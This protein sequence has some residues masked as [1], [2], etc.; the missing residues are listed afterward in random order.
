[1]FKKP[2]IDVT[3]KDINELLYIECRREDLNLDYK[4]DFYKD[5]KEFSKDLT[6]FANSN[7]GFIILGIDEKENEVIG[8]KDNVGRGKIEDWISNV[9]VNNIDKTVD[10]NLHFIIVDETN[11]L[12]IV[13]IEIKEHTDKPVYVISDSKTVCYLRKGTSIFSANPN[14]IKEMYQKSLYKKTN[15]INKISQK[16]KGNNNLQVVNNQGTI[17]KT[18]KI[19]NKNEI[20]PDPKIHISETEAKQIKEKIDEIVEINFLAKNIDKGKLYPQIWKSFYKKFNLTSYKLLDKSEFNDAVN[21]LQAQIAYNHRPKLRKNNNEL[22]KL[23]VYGAIYARAKNELNFNKEQLYDFAF[24]KLKL[25]SPIT[26]LKDLSDTRLN[27][28]YNLMFSNKELE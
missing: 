6:A 28:L 20:K 26:S 1:M 13:I 21:W 19:I 18:D 11:K 27:K 14:E 12:Y 25:K 4:R 15:T 23:K 7:G 17:I 5:G 16:I 22:W 2:L 24:D 3:Y 8:I 10:Y 9:L